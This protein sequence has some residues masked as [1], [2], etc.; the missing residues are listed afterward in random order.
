[1]IDLLQALRGIRRYPGFAALVIGT[2]A[3]GIGANTTIYSLVRAVFLRPLSF[4]DQER[5]VTLWERDSTRGIEDRRV[6][7]ANFVDWRAQT[8]A[9]EELGVLPN[10][11]GPGWHFNIAGH[12]G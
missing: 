4:P 5:L 12:D 7:P 3:I 6:T 8:T 10:W 1:M 2:M 11:S 9:F